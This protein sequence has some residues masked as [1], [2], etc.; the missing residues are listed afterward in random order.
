M[1]DLIVLGAVFFIIGTFVATL[2][3]VLA[4]VL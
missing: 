4:G 2:V 3:A 1:K